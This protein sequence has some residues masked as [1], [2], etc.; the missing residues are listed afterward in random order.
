MHAVAPMQEYDLWDSFNGEKDKTCPKH[1]RDSGR[2]RTQGSDGDTEYE[3]ENVP[4][5]SLGTVEL[6]CSVLT[7]L[8]HWQ[9]AVFI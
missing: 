6:Y 9:P 1:L 8:L 2:G 5:V 7:R 4:E 3:Q